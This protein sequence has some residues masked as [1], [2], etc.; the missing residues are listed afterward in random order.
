MSPFSRVLPSCF[1][2]L[3]LPRDLPWGL[4]FRDQSHFP[5][6]DG[7]WLCPASARLELFISLHIT[8]GYRPSFP[9]LYSLLLALGMLLVVI[10]DCLVACTH[11]VRPTPG[12][13]VS[14]LSC[15]SCPSICR[16]CCLHQFLGCLPVVLS[17]LRTTF[18]CNSCFAPSSFFGAF[19]CS[20]A[21]LHAWCATA[22]WLPL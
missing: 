18:P 14:F 22:S 5:L 12:L 7:Y 3:P 21:P 9:Q 10:F 13:I 2:S 11:L 15:L 19:S 16:A 8:L 6:Q 20:L 17:G 4:G 1:G